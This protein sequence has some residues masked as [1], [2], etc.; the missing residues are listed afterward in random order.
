MDFCCFFC[1]P[2]SNCYF[3]LCFCSTFL[4]FLFLLHFPTFP[5]PHT[6]L[7]SVP[8]SS[9]KFFWGPLLPRFSFSIP[10]SSPVLSCHVRN[11]D[12][13]MIFFSTVTVRVLRFSLL[14][15]V[16]LFN[17][18]NYYAFV[19]FII[20]GF[21]ARVLSPLKAFVGICHRFVV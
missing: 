1:F 5:N 21:F 14:L 18:H 19:H 11:M 20:Q 9:P 3:C 10:L 12:F 2:A 15:R 17:W 6:F 7:M 8:I 16:L 13:I 4:Y